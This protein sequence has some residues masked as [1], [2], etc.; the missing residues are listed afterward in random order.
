MTKLVVTADDFGADIAV[1]EAVEAAHQDGILT[2]ASLMVGAPAVADAVARARRNPGLGVGLHLVLVEGRPVLPAG[3][4]R[5]LVGPDG[6][7]RTDMARL[8]LAIALSPAVRRQVRAEIAAQFAAFAATGLACDHVNAHK[9]FHV[10]PMIGAILLDEA[11]RHGV[12]AIRAPVEPGRPRGSGW[13]AAPFARALRS[14]ARAR[15]LTAPDQVYGLA[16]SGHMTA[17][18]IADAVAALPEGLSELYLHP[19][20]LDDFPGHGPGYRHRAE[21]DG[22]VTPAAREAV[23]ARGARLGSFTDFLEV[24]A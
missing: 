23:A 16:H 4:V 3:E 12:R 6:L 14:R 11:A 17:A 8:G 18:R 9:H 22:L 1:N 24:A 21:F 15:G 7:F 5:D 20:M 19:A 10:H 13:L 2:A